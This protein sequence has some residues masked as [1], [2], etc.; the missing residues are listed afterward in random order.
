MRERRIRTVSAWMVPVKELRPVC[1]VFVRSYEVVFE[2]LPVFW[3][4]P[5]EL[6]LLKNLN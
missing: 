3:E 6:M 2:S 5:S 1:M 4:R